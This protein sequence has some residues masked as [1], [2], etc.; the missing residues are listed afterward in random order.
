MLAKAEKLIW[1]QTRGGRIWLHLRENE[2]AGSSSAA[3]FTDIS[4]SV[5]PPP[6]ACSRYGNSFGLEDHI[7]LQTHGQMSEQF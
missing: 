4:G 1:S 2:R 6:T 3:F 5:T 7:A